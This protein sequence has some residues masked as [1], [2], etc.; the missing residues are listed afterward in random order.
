M[1]MDDENEGG[2]ESPKSQ[3]VNNAIRG[4]PAC[5]E[6]TGTA[7][8]TTYTETSGPAGLGPSE[9]A[10]AKLATSD[11]AVRESSLN[12]ES[13]I[14][15]MLGTTDAPRDILGLSGIE[16][17]EKFSKSSNCEDSEMSVQM[18]QYNELFTDVSN[19]E[20]QTEV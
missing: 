3:P 13:N 15:H 17:S 9:P 4:H 20:K 1:I 2:S 19:L 11:I 6:T 8:H 18:Q 10:S 14:S 16:N 5:S 12:T 7:E